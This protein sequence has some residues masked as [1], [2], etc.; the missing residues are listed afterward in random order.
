M[1]TAFHQIV[2]GIIDA[3]LVSPAIASG[4]VDRPRRHP[5]PAEWASH[6]EVRLARAD[7]EWPY[8]GPNTPGQ[9]TSAIA[10]DCY[11]RAN[12]GD[13]PDATLDALLDATHQDLQARHPGPF[14]LLARHDVP[15]RQFVI[16]AREH[17]LDGRPAGRIADR[18]VLRAP[19]R[20]RAGSRRAA[21]RACRRCNAL[22]PFRD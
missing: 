22:A 1:S 14:L 21:R 17:L 10:V 5:V 19:A 12:P 8:V 13:Q 15:R 18:C 6:V 4:H 9:W 16:G 20:P 3:L 11:A 2:Q 7:G